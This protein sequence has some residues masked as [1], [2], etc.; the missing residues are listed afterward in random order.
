[1]QVLACSGGCIDL[2]D[3]DGRR[4]KAIAY[5]RF[6]HDDW[7]LAE[8]SYELRDYPNTAAALAA[9]RTYTCR[10]D[11]PDSDPAEAA[12]LRDRGFSSLLLTPLSS[13]GR[14]IGIIEL[15]DTRPRVFTTADQ[16]TA[17]AL[18]HHLAPLLALLG[19]T[20]IIQRA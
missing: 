18:A 12:L 16:R 8:Q 6:G 14:A 7:K 17:L 2:L 1:V 19:D 9:G 11:D 10:I 20:E 4:V 3:P 13:R 15:F 5:Y